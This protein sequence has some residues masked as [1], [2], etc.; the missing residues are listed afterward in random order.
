MSIHSKTRLL[1]HIV[2]ST[3]KR[4]R[5]IPQPLRIEM[6][7]YLRQYSENHSIHIIAIYVNADH[8]HLLIDLDP[9]HSIASVVKLLKGSS[10]R[11]LNQH[12]AHKTKFSWGRG[13]GAFSVSQS[14]APKVMKYIH[15]Q[16]DHHRVKS[17]TEEFEVFMSAYKVDVRNR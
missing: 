17:F 8:V 15:N 7:D 1:T 16:E 9:T 2:W 3:Y 14:N 6:N 11:W 4:G 10:S 13:Y 5:V 12:D